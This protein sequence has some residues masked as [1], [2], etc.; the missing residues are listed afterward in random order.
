[1]FY[2]L[3]QSGRNELAVLNAHAQSTEAW[4]FRLTMLAKRGINAS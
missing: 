1:M 4:I 3:E 2:D